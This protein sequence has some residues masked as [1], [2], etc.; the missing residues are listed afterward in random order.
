M[1]SLGQGDK[2]FLRVKLFAGLRQ[3]V[4]RGCGLVSILFAYAFDRGASFRWCRF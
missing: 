4:R 2:R 1:R 3:L